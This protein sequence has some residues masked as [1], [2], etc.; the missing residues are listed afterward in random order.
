MAYKFKTV[1]LFAG[2]GGIKRGFELTGKAVNVLA[3][4]NDKYA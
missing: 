3:A 4:E 1:D 2:I